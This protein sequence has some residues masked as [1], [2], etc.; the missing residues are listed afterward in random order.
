ML[1]ISQHSPTDRISKGSSST[2]ISLFSCSQ[3]ILLCCLSIVTPES[4]PFLSLHFFE[5]EALK[6]ENHYA[7]VSLSQ[8]TRVIYLYLPFAEIG[9]KAQGCIWL[10]FTAMRNSV[11]VAKCSKPGCCY[12]WLDV[13]KCL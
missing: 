6:H 7:A 11:A 12:S 2:V 10:L 8:N 1:Y 13:I 4:I 3:L 9:V 5:A